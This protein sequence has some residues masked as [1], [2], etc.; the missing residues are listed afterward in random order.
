M[1]SNLRRVLPILGAMLLMP[2]LAVAHGGEEHA[3]EAQVPM[4]VTMENGAR[5]ALSSPDVE[6][7]GVFQD[8]KLTL[9]A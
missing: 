7:S 9:Y 6:L 4:S 8:G 5:M 1:L 2:V 3:D